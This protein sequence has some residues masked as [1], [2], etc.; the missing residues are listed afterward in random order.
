MQGLDD[1]KAEEAHLTNDAVKGKSQ[2]ADE[3]NIFRWQI[4]SDI[5]LRHMQSLTDGH[6]DMWAYCE[7]SQGT[8]RAIGS[9][10]HKLLKILF[11]LQFRAARL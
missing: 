9:A 2:S 6:P 3:A 5:Y 1:V 7:S 11:Q 10:N 4:H 8:L